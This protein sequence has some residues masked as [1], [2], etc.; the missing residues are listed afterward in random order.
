MLPQE[1]DTPQTDE[2]PVIIETHDLSRIYPGV[3]ALSDQSV[4]ELKTRL[5]P[6]HC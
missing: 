1:I 2:S 6:V 4:Q 3:V 5:R